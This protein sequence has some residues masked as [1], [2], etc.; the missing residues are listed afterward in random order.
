M[1]IQHQKVIG[2]IVLNVVI[3]S[4]KSYNMGYW[5]KDE[6]SGWKIWEDN[7]KAAKTL[8]KTHKPIML[9]QRMGRRET[10]YDTICNG[11]GS[12]IKVKFGKL[13]EPLE[14]KFV[15][16]P[17]SDDVGHGIWASAIKLILN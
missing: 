17:N 2:I 1:I 10:G 14:E 5:T 13:S 16:C 15:P 12:P 3:G 7:I 6:L 8:R 11:C 9:S 4:L